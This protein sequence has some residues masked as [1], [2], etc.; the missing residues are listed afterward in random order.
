MVGFE[1]VTVGALMAML[2]WMRRPSAEVLLYAWCPL[3]V[4]EIAGSGHV[5][6][7][8]LCFVTLALVAR[9]RDWP[10]LTGLLLGCAVMTKFYPLVLLPALWKR[11]DWKMPAAVAAVCVAGYAMYSS[12]GLL[13]LGFLGGYSQEEGLYSGARFFLLAAVQKLHGLEHLPV[14]AYL[15]FCVAVMGAICW[16]CWKFVTVEGCSTPLIAPKKGAMNGPP[17]LCS[18][19]FVKGAMMLAMAMMLLFSPHYPWYIVWLVPFF[20]LIPN[21]PLLVYLMGMFY[22]CTTLLA[23]GTAANGFILNEILYGGMAA[24]FV[25][26]LIVRQWPV[27]DLLR[28]RWRGAL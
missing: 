7:A 25:L 23:D 2:R 17:D 3:A 28:S 19:V 27:V 24:A 12:A 14:A 8:V 22:L 20:V 15:V 18:P 26:H 11:G 10:V 16:W 5:D 13:V 4:W 9:W 6:A 1:C 21:L